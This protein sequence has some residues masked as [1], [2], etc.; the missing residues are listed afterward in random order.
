M[1]GSLLRS[2][3]VLTI[4]LTLAAE[5][6]AQAVLGP[7][8]TY[9]ENFDSMGDSGTTPPTGW[10]LFQIAGGSS[11]WSNN[12]G[13]NS[14][15]AIGGIPNGTAI[16]DGTASAGLVVN[17][18]PTGSQINGYNALGASGAAGDRG[19]ATAPTGIAGNAIQLQITNNSGV[20]VTDLLLS[21]DMRRYRV[22]GDDA[23]RNPPAG[24]PQGSEELPGYSL[25]Y[26]LDNGANYTAFN[27]LIPVGEGPTTNPIVPNTL[28]VTSVADAAV[29][30]DAPWTPG[31]NLFL[32]WVDDNAI[33]PSPDEIIGLDNVSLTAV[34]EPA[35]LV[36]SGVVLLIVGGARWRRRTPRSA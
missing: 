24:I 18:N 23:G 11:T 29:S 31:S 17:N 9:S 28:G 6:N 19:I 4:S 22:G 32:R 30:L 13:S 20:P 10:G 15:P 12:T 1:I 5:A 26:S 7:S 36:L 34:P 35:S 25:F 2:V 16:A 21:Y 14:T 27:S 3:C 8:L 33:D